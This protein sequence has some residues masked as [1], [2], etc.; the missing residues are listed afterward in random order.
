LFT[1]SQLGRLRNIRP[2]FTSAMPYSR[3][4]AAAHHM[5]KVLNDVPAKDIAVKRA[6]GFEWAVSRRWRT[7]SASAS[8]TA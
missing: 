3:S 8:R 1:A 7:P 5:H 4:E 6:G 2:R